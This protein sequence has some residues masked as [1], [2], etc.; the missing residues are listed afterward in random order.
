MSGWNTSAIRSSVPAYLPEHI[1]DACIRTTRGWEIP[2]SGTANPLADREVIV[3]MGESDFI[4]GANT[5]PRVYYRDNIVNYRAGAR[6]TDRDGTRIFTGVSGA[7]ITPVYIDVF[8]TEHVPASGTVTAI[9]SG[10]PAGLSF[11]TAGDYTFKLQ[12][13]PITYGTFSGIITFS[14]A[15]GSTGVYGMTWVI[16]AS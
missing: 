1:K 3:S 11:V 16:S 7:A 13:T 8:D 9:T 10:L 14:D 2:A 12:G 15:G 5:S 4:T 6:I